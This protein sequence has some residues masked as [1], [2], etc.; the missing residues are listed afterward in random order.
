VTFDEILPAVKTG[1]RATRGE[2][3]K[4]LADL[5]GCWLELACPSLP[6]GRPLMPVLVVAYPGESPVLR[7]FAGA[8]WDLL[9]EDWELLLADS[10]GRSRTIADGDGRPWTR[11]IL[12]RWP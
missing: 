9:A 11:V 4:R 8:N 1:G 10:P 5:R 6:D 3:N 7:P 12:L 2:W